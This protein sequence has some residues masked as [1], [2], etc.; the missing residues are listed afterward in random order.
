MRSMITILTSF[1]PDLPTN[2]YIGCASERL[3]FPVPVSLCCSVLFLSLVQL[4]MTH[5]N[6]QLLLLLL[7]FALILTVLTVFP[8]YSPFV[9]SFWSC[10]HMSS[11]PLMLFS[12]LYSCWFM[13]VSQ[14]SLPISQLIMLYLPCIRGCSWKSWREVQDIYNLLMKWCHSATSFIIPYFA[15]LHLESSRFFTSFGDSSHA[16]ASVRR[17]TEPERVKAAPLFCLKLTWISIS[18]DR[19]FLF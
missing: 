16:L 1:T 17:L 14:L 18:K 7:F 9:R 2:E 19:C 12:S 11:K 15:N 10:P 6:I 4:N 13:Q 5:T 3:S 8:P